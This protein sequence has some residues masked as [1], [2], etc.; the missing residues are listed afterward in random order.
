MSNTITILG[1]DPS[2]A[3]WGFALVDVNV[4]TLE[5][6]PQLIKLT[7][8][9]KSK[10]KQVRASSDKL[11]RGR[12]LREAFLSHEAKAHINAAEVPSG[13]QSATAATALGIATGV[14][15]CH[16]KPLIEVSPTEVKKS[17]TGYATASKE[18]MI[19]WATD[20]WPDLDWLA[21]RAIL[22][23]YAQDNEHLADALAIVH[24]AIRTEQFKQA[25]AMFSI[26]NAA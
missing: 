24:T 25:A 7:K 8:T 26:V 21:G 14:L 3:N 2:L 15:A 18:E 12:Q 5:M 17:V 23:K 4:D 16:H 6:K 9:V 13:T 19:E 10:N 1:H 11:M 20:L 22:G